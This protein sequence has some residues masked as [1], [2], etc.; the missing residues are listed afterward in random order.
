MILHDDKYYFSLPVF[1][2]L[3][4]GF[5]WVLLFFA[6]FAVFLISLFQLYTALTSNY[7]ENCTSTVHNDFPEIQHADLITPDFTEITDSFSEFWLKD[8]YSQ[9]IMEYGKTETFTELPSKEQMFLF[10]RQNSTSSVSSEDSMTI[11]H[12]LFANDLVFANKLKIDNFTPS[13]S[14][15]WACQ[16]NEQK[17]TKNFADELNSLSE[18]VKFLS[19]S[20]EVSHNL[21]MPELSNP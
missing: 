8:D 7:S 11:A 1:C 19:T 18:T 4:A 12:S 20:Q 13:L 15:T 17:H 6:V 21:L 9:Y 14:K 3:S 5:C 10:L 2:C 16:Q